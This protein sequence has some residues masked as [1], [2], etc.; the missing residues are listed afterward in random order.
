[1]ANGVDDESCLHAVGCQEDGVA[2]V[3]AFGHSVL[4]DVADDGL[5]PDVG[6]R[7]VC[8]SFGDVDLKRVL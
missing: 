8:H 2:V 7:F 1:M 5:E 3:E 4:C 6:V